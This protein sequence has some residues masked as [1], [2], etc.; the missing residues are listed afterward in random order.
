[1]INKA[2]ET[3]IEVYADIARLSYEETVSGT[4]Y[5]AVK[6]LIDC[7]EALGYANQTY[8]TCGWGSNHQEVFAL[9]HRPEKLEQ[10]TD[11]ITLSNKHDEIRE[12]ANNLAKDTRSRLIKLQKQYCKPS[13]LEKHLTDYYPG[14]LEYV[15]KIKTAEAKE[16]KTKAVISAY[17]IQAELTHMLRHG[18]TGASN[19]RFNTLR[20]TSEQYHGH[21]LPDL[22]ENI[23]TLT[24]N[25]DRLDTETQK[26]FNKLGLSVNKV[27]K[28]ADFTKNMREKCVN[29]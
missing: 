26:L 6:T 19:T 23:E 3:Y 20:E 21:G 4:R 29:T 15:N 8:F 14:I 28:L 13:G 22:L 10:Y 5:L 2:L 12:A 18:E 1:M 25:A 9:K 24:E 11:T 17:T 27:E 7:S 16:N